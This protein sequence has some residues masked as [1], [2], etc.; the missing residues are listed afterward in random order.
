MKASKA[1][2]N[3]KTMLI[4]PLSA[5]ILASSLL[6]GNLYAAEQPLDRVAAIVDNDVVM[7]SQYQSRLKEVPQTTSKRGVELPPDDVLRQQVMERLIIDAI[8]LIG[9]SISSKS[10]ILL[11]INYSIPSFFKCLIMSSTVSMFSNSS[12][13]ISISN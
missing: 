13:G 11:F 9:N 1:T 5:L 8:Q 12:V 6:V 4:K 3:V 10:H 7:Y 2:V